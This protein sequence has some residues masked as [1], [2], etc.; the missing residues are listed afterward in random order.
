M[1]AAVRHIKLFPHFLH[2]ATQ[3]IPIAPQAL[4]EDPRPWQIGI[5][6]QQWGLCR[7]G[8]GQE[9]PRCTTPGVT[10]DDAC[11]LTVLTAERLGHD[12]IAC[13]AHHIATRRII[14]GVLGAHVRRPTRKIDRRPGA[15][16]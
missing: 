6:R 4:H 15:R 1:P 13:L 5:Q 12:A 2:P 8:T 11:L 3:T 7:E 9:S 10:D 16:E 14:D